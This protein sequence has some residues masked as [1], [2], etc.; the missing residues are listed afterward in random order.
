MN[1]SRQLLGKDCSVGRHPVAA[2]VP[3]RHMASLNAGCNP[4]DRRD[5]IQHAV[6][7]PELGRRLRVESC[8]TNPFGNNLGFGASAAEGDP[9]AAGPL[10]ETMV[11]HLRHHWNPL[12]LSFPTKHQTETCL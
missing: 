3:R 6:A 7:I 11:G 10:P 4:S 5:L 9:G 2:T 8:L 1:T 12:P